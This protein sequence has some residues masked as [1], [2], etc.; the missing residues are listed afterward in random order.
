MYPAF[1]Q[2]AMANGFKGGGYVSQLLFKD[3]LWR[4]WASVVTQLVKN[5]PAMR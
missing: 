1:C 2:L 5:L 4:K 3:P